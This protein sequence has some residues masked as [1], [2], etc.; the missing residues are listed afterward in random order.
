MNLILEGELPDKVKKLW[1]T[2]SPIKIDG[3][4]RYMAV[5]EKETK[6]SN[7]KVKIGKS[8][9]IEGKWDELTDDENYCNLTGGIVS[10]DYVRQSCI[11]TIAFIKLN[12]AGNELMSETK[13]VDIPKFISNHVQ[14]Y[15]D[16]TSSIGKKRIQL[17]IIQ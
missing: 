15:T 9:S 17:I 11:N 14:N 10:A 4:E 5:T 16:K 3:E 1:K 13:I 7:I 8:L 2:G 6:D 12:Y